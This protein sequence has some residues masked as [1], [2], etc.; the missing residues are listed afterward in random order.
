MCLEQEVLVVEQVGAGLVD[1]DQVGGA[2]DDQVHGLEGRDHH[3]VDGAGDE[4]QEHAVGEVLGE[5]CGGRRH[6]T[7]PLGLRL[8]P[9]HDG[10]VGQDAGTVAG[11]VSTAE[12]HL[13]RHV[14]H[15]VLPLVHPVH[16]LVDPGVVHVEHGH[17]HTGEQGPNIDEAE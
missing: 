11:V 13:G 7:D 4:D 6:L 16:T 8:V 17:H 2:E 5:V 1:D 10:D 12:L 9:V 3:L 14:I 15:L